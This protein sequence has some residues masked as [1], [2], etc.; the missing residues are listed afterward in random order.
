LTPNLTKE[1]KNYIWRVVDHA[2]DKAGSHS[3][4]FA[5]RLEFFE[6]SGRIRFNWPVWMQA[7]RGYLNYQYGEKKT[8]TMLAGILREVMSE[9][10]YSAY[11]RQTQGNADKIKQYGS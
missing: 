4:L 6:E 8:D 9:S 10:N 5:N 7:I 11:L 1:D 2:V 3:K